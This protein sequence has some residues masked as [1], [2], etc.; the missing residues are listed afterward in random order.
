MAAGIQAQD[1]HAAKPSVA[2]AAIG[3]GAASILVSTFTLIPRK[4]ETP[5]GTS[6]RLAPA[7]SLSRNDRIRMGLAG[8]LRF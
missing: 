7:L 2:R 6:L 3:T 4:A 1:D 8:R 5:A